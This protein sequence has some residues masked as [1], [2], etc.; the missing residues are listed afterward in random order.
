M[1][2]IIIK[3]WNI[4]PPTPEDIESAKNTKDIIYMPNFCKSNTRWDDFINHADFLSKNLEL[5]LPSPVPTVGAIQIWDSFFHAG[6][7][8]KN[9]GAFLQYDELAAKTKDLYGR[10]P[11]NGCTLVNFIG[12]RSMIPIHDDV[13]DSFYW[14]AINQVEW[15]IYN[16]YDNESDYTPLTVKAGEALFVPRGLIHS[17]FCKEPR[18]AI[19]L[20]Y[21]YN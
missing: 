21:D 6:Y 13:R 14:Q 5:D 4:N 11:N 8:L 9:S 19:S 17:V 16:S 10:E 1:N 12:M 3:D 18:A 7:Y 2:N 15:R 20:F